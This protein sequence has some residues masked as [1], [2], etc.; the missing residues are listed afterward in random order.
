VSHALTRHRHRRPLH[1]V[2]CLSG[3]VAFFDWNT[4]PACN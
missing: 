1:A 4:S 2:G 3:R